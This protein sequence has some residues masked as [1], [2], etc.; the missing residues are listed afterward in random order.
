MWSVSMVSKGCALQLVHTLS[1][2]DLAFQQKV[3]ERMLQH[4]LVKPMLP[5]YLSNIGET[6]SDHLIVQSIKFGVFTH[7]IK[8]CSNKHCVTK[9]LLTY[10]ATTKYASGRKVAKNLGLDWQCIYQIL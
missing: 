10:L 7:P 9:E 8:G 5:T 4:K 3:L 6:K 1:S 2:H